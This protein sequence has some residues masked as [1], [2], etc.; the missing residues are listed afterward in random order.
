M[1]RC[2][3]LCEPPARFLLQVQ[4][5]YQVLSAKAIQ[6]AI[7]QIADRERLARYLGQQTAMITARGCS[8]AYATARSGPGA[9]TAGKPGLSDLQVFYAADGKPVSAAKSPWLDELG[10]RMD[11]SQASV[12]RDNAAA[13][14]ATAFCIARAYVR[15]GQSQPG[16]QP[17][18]KKPVQLMGH[19]ARQRRPERAFCCRQ[20]AYRCR[21]SRRT[22]TAR[23]QAL[24]TARRPAP[25]GSVFSA[26]ST[27]VFRTGRRRSKLL[28][29]VARHILHSGRSPTS[30]SLLH[31][32]LDLSPLTRPA[33]LC[34]N[35]S[36]T[37]AIA[38]N[39]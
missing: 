33:A 17:A 21:A 30:L 10:S 35:A 29:E 2:E 20:A 38:N 13:T 37:C 19:C 8:T 15:A 4:N 9:D 32:R 39:F 22:I 31:H 25:E 16:N 34:N 27:G 1:P 12:E 11:A 6:I 28:A 5:S 24:P 3:M 18:R 26:K 14:A 36:S 7:T 23:W